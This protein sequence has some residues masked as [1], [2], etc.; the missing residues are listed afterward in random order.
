MA[1]TL[2]FLPPA[3]ESGR[4]LLMCGELEAGAV[5]PPVGTNPGKH[6][7]VWRFWL[8]G[9]DARHDKHGR[10]ASEDAAKAALIKA[11]NEWLRKAGL[12]VAA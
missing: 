1:D 3:Y 10:A 12:E 7:W 5:F 2:R 4:R 8:G 6:P 9:I 11:T